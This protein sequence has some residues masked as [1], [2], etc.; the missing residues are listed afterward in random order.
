MQLAETYAR[1]KNSEGDV[2]AAGGLLFCSQKDAVAEELYRY[3]YGKI[4]FVT[5]K[6]SY[7]F[8]SAY[9]QSPRAVNVCLEGEDALPLFAMPEGVI[10][11]FAAGGERVMRAVRY[12]CGV[13]RVNGI[14][15]P[16]DARLGGVLEGEGE[17]LIGGV[18]GN[19]PLASARVYCD[20]LSMKRSFPDAYARLMLLR[21]AVFE[22]RALDLWRREDTDVDNV[23]R[24][25]TAPCEGWTEEE[26]VV[27]N[28]LL[29]GVDFG[30]GMALARTLCGELHAEWSAFRFLSALYGAFFACGKPRRYVVPDYKARLRA[31]GKE[32]EYFQR[33]IPTSEE[34]ARQAVRLEAIRKP[35]RRDFC[36]LFCGR[37]QETFLRMGG[38]NLPLPPNSLLFR[39]PEYAP[40]GLCGYMR[41]FG[42]LE[43]D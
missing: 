39:L 27:R 15:I 6:R 11:V 9:A 4:L 14:L 18:K 3:P 31:I 7:A 16:T 30:E 29:A 24:A 43:N 23:F 26:I 36:T 25:T 33:H 37:E 20:V 10:A 41:D 34:L 12:F 28:A 32:A 21:L 13:S 35:L 22:R 42:L 2:R 40:N 38:K 8:F 5:D 19:Y 17:V 1:K